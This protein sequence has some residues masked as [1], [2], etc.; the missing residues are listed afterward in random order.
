MDKIQARADNDL[1]GGILIVAL[2]R[3][4]GVDDLT[5]TKILSL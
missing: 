3:A 1:Y 5:W 4:W 2:P